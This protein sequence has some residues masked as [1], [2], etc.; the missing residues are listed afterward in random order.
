MSHRDSLYQLSGIIAR[1]DALTGGRQRGKQGR[2]ASGKNNVLITC[3]SKD[4]KAGY[5]AMESVD[6]LCH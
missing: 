5:I 1:D 3:E 2:G 4:R 6:S